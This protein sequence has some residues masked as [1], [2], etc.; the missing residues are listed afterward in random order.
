MTRIAVTGAAGSVGGQVVQL[1][2]E[3]TTNEVVGLT[4][5]P[6]PV[7]SR[8]VVAIADYNDRDALSR[9]LAG[10]DTLV[11]I[12]SDG[13]GT[14]VLTHHLNIIAAARDGGVAHIVALSGIDADI[15]SPF[16]YAITNG[17]TE[18]AIRDSGCGYSIARASIFTEFF[19]HFIL[20]ARTTGQCGC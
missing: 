17:L 7:P 15:D 11:L 3:Q 19:A 12:S 8:A 5:R 6:V 14:R 13:E 16:C 10:V 2:A 18:Q 20:P 4:R 9:A 1:L